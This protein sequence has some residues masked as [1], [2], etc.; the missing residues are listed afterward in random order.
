MYGGKKKL[1]LLHFSNE[2]AMPNRVTFKESRSV[3]LS[4]FRWNCFMMQTLLSLA[5]VPLKKTVLICHSNHK[6]TEWNLKM[7]LC[8]KKEWENVQKEMRKAAVTDVLQTGLNESRQQ[9]KK[10]KGDK[11]RKIVPNIWWNINAASTLKLMTSLNS[12]HLDMRSSNLCHNLLNYP[13]VLL[14]SQCESFF[15]PALM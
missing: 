6:T 8:I 9:K 14:C 4:W 1:P 10:K 7:A 11:G 5:Y 15:V 2:M 12:K 13:D 3:T